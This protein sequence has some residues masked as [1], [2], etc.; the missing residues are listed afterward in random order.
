[1][2]KHNSGDSTAHE[3]HRTWKSI[4]PVVAR[5]G[6]P[7]GLGLAT[8]P[9][10]RGQGHPQ[11]WRLCAASLDLRRATG[12][13]GTTASMPRL[14]ADLL[15][16]ISSAGAGQL[17]RARSASLCH[18]SLA[19]R[20]QL[21]AQDSGMGAFPSGTS[22]AVVVMVAIGEARV[23]D[24]AKPREAMSFERKHSASL[25]RWGWSSGPRERGWAA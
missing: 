14:W 15:R 1:M 10:L 9:S 19:T 8:V 7:L 2:C 13:T 3:H 6:Q 18:R 5:V 11:E 17:V 23:G 12:S 22:R 25:A 24:A 20:R 4:C 16:T 21:I